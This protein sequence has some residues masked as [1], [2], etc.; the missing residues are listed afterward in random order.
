MFALVVDQELA[1][2]VTLGGVVLSLVGVIAWVLKSALPSLLRD[3]GDRLDRIQTQHSKE[4]TEARQE[5]RAEISFFRA[6]L[7]EMNAA[8]AS[9]NTRLSESMDKLADEISAL[10]TSHAVMTGT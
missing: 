9:M 10:K 7:K 1:G 6:D 8:N 5:F 4:L 3:F 2:G